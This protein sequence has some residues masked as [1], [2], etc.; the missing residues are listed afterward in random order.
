MQIYKLFL[1]IHILFTIKRRY[2]C[3][4]KKSRYKA[5]MHITLFLNAYAVIWRANFNEITNRRENR[6]SKR[7]KRNN[8]RTFIVRVTPYKFFSVC[9]FRF[10]R[11]FRFCSADGRAKPRQLV[12]DDSRL[13][14]SITHKS[15]LKVWGRWLKWR[16]RLLSFPSCG[17]CSTTVSP[18]A[19]AGGTQSGPTDRAFL[20]SSPVRNYLKFFKRWL[21]S[22]RP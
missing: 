9:N 11:T 3:L 8:S 12:A 6:F 10:W 21:F 7:I 22:G 16:T 4:Q 19:T 18:W 15:A 1:I 14:R 20:R 13:C 2:V 5:H 17:W